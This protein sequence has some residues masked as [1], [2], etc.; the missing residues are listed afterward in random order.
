[1]IEWGQKSK[2]QK[3][4]RASNKTPKKFLDQKLTPKKSLAEFLSLKNF[5]EALINE[6]TR[7]TLCRHY[8]ESSDCFERPKNPYLN[9]ATQKMYLRNIPT[10]KK[11]RNRKFQT[12][13]NPSIILVT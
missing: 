13:T 8:R 2:A 3:I 7:C 9:K 10:P 6:I 12:Q 5:Q 1:M 11:S 4:P